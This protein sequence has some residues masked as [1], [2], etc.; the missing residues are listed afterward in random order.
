MGIPVL[1]ALDTLEA[2]SQLRLQAILRAVK[3]SL[4]EG[5]T[6]G[7]ALAK[8]PDTF[9]NGYLALIRSGE[10]AGELC[11][12]LDKCWRTAYARPSFSPSDSALPFSLD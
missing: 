1:D 3:A 2:E 12:V 7:D 4:A 5:L 6:L 9:D 8:H 10:A 11:P